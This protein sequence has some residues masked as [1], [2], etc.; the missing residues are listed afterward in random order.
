PGGVTATDSTVQVTC[1][2]ANDGEIWVN[3]T[4]GVPAYQYSLNG[5]PLQGGSSFTNLV[6]GSYTIV[7]QDQLGCA[8]TINVVIG[9]PTALSAADS[10]N[11]LSCFPGGGGEIWIINPAGGTPGYQYSL[12]GGPLQSNPGFTALGAGTFEVSMTDANG[13][14]LVI[15]T[16]TI[17]PLIPIQASTY[18]NDVTCNGAGNGEIGI[19]QV[20]GGL[21]P[22]TYSIDSL[23]WGSNPLFGGLN[24]GIHTVWILD[25]LGCTLSLTDTIGEPAP[26]SIQ[27]T[28]TQPTCSGNDGAIHLLVTGGVSPYTYQWGN[29][30]TAD[31]LSG[32]GVG[33][34]FVT[35]TDNLL[36]QDTLV[37]RLSGNGTSPVATIV[38]NGN[39][40]CF[41]GQDGWAAATVTGGTAP[42]QYLWNSPVPVTGDTL[43]GVGA[44]VWTV[45]VTDALGCVS[46]DSVTVTEPT[47]LVASLDSVPVTCFAE[48]NGSLSA[49]ASGGTPLYSYLWNSGD[50]AALA[51]NL[52]A[53]AYSVTV[54]DANGCQVIATQTLSDP[55]PVIAGF[56]S[57]PSMPAQLQFPN[58]LVTFQNTSQNADFYSWNFGDGG[59]DSNVDPSHTYDV[60]GDY[61]VV[62]V[63]E[64]S[65][66]CT[67]TL[68]VCNFAVLPLEL[69]IPNTFTPN[70]DGRNDVFQIVGI[71]LYPNNHLAVYNRWGNL[72]YEKDQYD[73][74]WKGDNYKNGAP[75]PDGAYYYIFTTGEEGQKG[76]LGD[77]VIFR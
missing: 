48:T 13:C 53:G 56:N 54:T 19:T 10:V 17:D 43:N 64:D 30:S 35:V 27:P 71:E 32:I 16:V 4:G 67:D 9:E 21:P 59:L 51:A 34:Y 29:G 49:I 61:C 65:A 69:D 55:L 73:N 40:S 75:L 23:T 37:V 31:S 1:N 25:S 22:Y 26:L 63:A 12:N 33:T 6:A 20:S 76:I 46:S 28:L 39:V 58:N 5:G 18:V 36:C 72:V 42:F 44:G 62:L 74:S 38:A 60:P 47:E 24:G 2:G 66:G 7:A 70:N 68:E 14:T 50:T 11:G 77:I 57:S 52:G 15:D 3:A 45:Y 8:A 41:G